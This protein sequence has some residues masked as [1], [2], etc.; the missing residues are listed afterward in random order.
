MRPLQLK[1]EIPALL[2][3]LFFDE[4]GRTF[5][6]KETID[7]DT[8]E[9]AP[10]AYGVN[11][12]DFMVAIEQLNERIMGVECSGYITGVGKGTVAQCFVVGDAVLCLLQAPVASRVSLR[13]TNVVHNSVG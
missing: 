12:R 9:I 7:E 6:Q 13:W 5:V 4:D 11:F 1:T 8:I 3:T 2:E 10:Q